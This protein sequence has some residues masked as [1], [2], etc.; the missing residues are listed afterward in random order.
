M[1]RLNNLINI[2]FNKLKNI[3][4]NQE[5]KSLK[6]ITINIFNNRKLTNSYLKK[7]FLILLKSFNADLICFQ[8]PNNDNIKELKKIGYRLII[9][10]EKKIIYIYI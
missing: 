3:S 1:N 8:E 6:I 9:N 10:N 2:H 4:I 7:N 5:N